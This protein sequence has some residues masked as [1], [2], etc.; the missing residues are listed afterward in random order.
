[1]SGLGIT[2][3]IVTMAN[4]D[5]ALASVQGTLWMAD[6]RVVTVT[7]D[8]AAPPAGLDA[9]PVVDVGRSWVLPGFIDMHNH[10]G[11]NTLP[12]WSEPS[13]EVP[14]EHSKSW[15]RADTY[16]GSVTEP[17][18]CLATAAPEA[19][20]AY[21]Q[22]RALVGGTA[23][24]QGWPT[25]NR[26]LDRVVRS[27]DADGGARSITQALPP[28]S[29][30]ELNRRAQQVRDGH[31]FVYHC[32][33]GRRGSVAAPQFAAAKRAGCLQPT[34]V[35]VH[36]TAVSADDW[37]T[38]PA[39]DAGGLVWSPFSNYWLYG[40]TTLVRDAVDRGV[41]LCLGSDWGPSGTK[42]ILGEL[43]VARIASNR[44]RFGLTDEDLV[45]AV[46]TGPGKILSKC[47]RDTVGR[48]VP[49]A[50]GGRDGGARARSA[51]GGTDGRRRP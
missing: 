8:G 39:D 33:E 18:W 41:T 27:V 14:F 19:L 1:M 7:L 38:W 46:T 2:G 12:L 16:T 34:F 5:D 45:A 29:P 21:V 6:G 26:T 9:A 11:Y 49:G 30:D 3:R 36:C 4:P 15:T 25:A 43:K 42:N 23:V 28:L 32:A 40:E 37:K 22:L 24:Q 51:N 10:I 13:Q 20:L 47:W 31:G 48:L 44:Q 17:A 35:G 50:L